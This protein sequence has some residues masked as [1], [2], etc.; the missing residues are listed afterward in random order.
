MMNIIILEDSSKA[1]FGGG[2]RITLDVIEVLTND[3]EV[4][5]FD[6]N[7]DSI[8]NK[9]LEEMHLESIKLESYSKDSKSFFS[10]CIKKIASFT[11]VLKNLFL[12]GSF[13]KKK[14]YLNK[15]LV[16][17]TTKKGLI[18][19]FMIKIIYGVDYVYHAHMIENKITEKL[20]SFLTRN[21]YKIIC[22]STKV[23]EQFRSSNSLVISNSIKV[24]VT[25]SK[26]IKGKKKFIVATISSLNYIKGI[27]YFVKSF[28]FLENKKVMYHIYGEGPLRSLLDYNNDNIVF[29]G[30]ALDV[31]E[32]LLEEI[33]ILVVPTIIPE[34]FGMVILEALSC[35]VP[36]IATNI[37][38]QKIHIVNSLAG[39]LIDIKDAKEMSKKID[40]ILS[41]E[42]TYESYSKRGLNYAKGFD[43]MV[44]TREIK[45]L[46]KSY[47]FTSK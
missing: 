20:V 34:S 38:M 44:F 5:I 23:E 14:K 25:T 32:I 8:F 45:G 19:A 16:Y 29:K 17:A 9:K 10:M 22:V 27:E 18:L 2:Q 47:D 46:F 21:A 24:P 26:T 36:V 40:Y 33:D 28:G 7:K 35:G 37:G 39:E 30:H 3:F 41:C 11:Y 15:S 13:L 4:C 12:I 43:N 6:T 1:G 42:D 31:I